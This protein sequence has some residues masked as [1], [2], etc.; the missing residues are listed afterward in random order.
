AGLKPLTRVVDEAPALDGDSLELARWIAEQSLSSLGSTLAAL[1]PPSVSEREASVS[2]RVPGMGRG[3]PETD[4]PRLRTPSAPAPAARAPDLAALPEVFIGVGREHRLL[5]RVAMTSTPALVIVPDVESA[6]R[7]TQRLEKDRSGARLDSGVDDQTR[8]LAWIALSA[9]SARLAVGTRSALLAPLPAGATLA[10]VD[11]HEAAHKPP[12]P[13]R[14]HSRDIVLE[15]A[16]RARLRVALTSATPSVETWW[17]ADSG[18]ARLVAGGSVPRPAGPI[19]GTR[20]GLQVRP[21]TPPLA[22]RGRG[23]APAGRGRARAAR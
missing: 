18:Q 7:W 17:R 13:P 11:E 3:W 22:R 10:L 2:E 5:E 8:E 23:G 9:G 19:A 12:G 20:G 1:M 21:P 4:G 14:M 15:R 6:G 16:A